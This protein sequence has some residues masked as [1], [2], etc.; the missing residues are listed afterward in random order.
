[1]KPSDIEIMLKQRYI[2]M[3][4]ED[5]EVINEMMDNP[6]TGSVIRKFIGGSIAN[7]LKVP[8]PKRMRMGSAVTMQP[9]GYIGGYDPNVEPAK[10]VADDK[11]MQAKEGD[12]IINAAAAEFAGKQDI[13]RMIST[14]ITSLQEKGVDVRFGNPTMNIREK[15]DLLVSQNEV[16]IPKEI[17]KEIGYDRL[18]KI[19][20]RGKRRTQEVQE[21]TQQAKSGGAVRKAQGDV[22]EQSGVQQA[23]VIDDIIEFG[24]RRFGI[25]GGG[26]LPS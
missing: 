25:G 17:A 7:N 21:Q 10:T 2:T 26:D 4:E 1:M 11:P 18:E 16:F 5:K 8:K 19:N 6:K 23:G 9:P 24:L 14:A 22:V 13:E 12:F 15:V 20:N 3:D